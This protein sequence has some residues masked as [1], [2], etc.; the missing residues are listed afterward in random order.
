VAFSL[1]RHPRRSP[2]GSHPAG[3]VPVVETPRPPA[4]P[5]Q[6][7]RMVTA[8]EV[9]TGTSRGETRLSDA[10]NGRGRVRLEDASIRPLAAPSIEGRVLPILELDPF[11]I[12]LVMA[13]PLPDEA[14]TRARRVHKV[15]YPV[16]IDAGR[17]QLEGLLHVFPGH[18]P[19]YVNHGGPNLFI[20]LTSARAWRA[21]RLVSDPSVDAILVNRHLVRSIAQTDVAL[22]QDATSLLLRRRVSEPS[23]V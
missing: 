9:V 21:G 14:W 15:R 17:Y 13:A 2:A 8:V 5:G 20:P 1:I 11:D 18:D 10:L 23:R 7:A 6:R 4:T 22:A 16:R 12:E 3:W 19:T